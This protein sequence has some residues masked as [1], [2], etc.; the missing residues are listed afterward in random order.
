MDIPRIY[1]TGYDLKDG[2]SI[3]YDFG[4][5]NQTLKIGPGHANFTFVVYKTDEPEWGFRA[6]VKKYYEL[7]PRFFEKR[8]EREGTVMWINPGISK[9]PN[10]SDFGFAFDVAHEFAYSG[11]NSRQRYDIEN[12]IY[13]FQYTEPWGWWRSFGNNSTKPS[14]GERIAT[15]EDDALNGENKTWRGIV[16]LNVAAQAVM[17]SAPYD[18]NGKMYLDATDY[19]WNYWGN[20]MQNYPTNPDPDIPPPNRFEISYKKYQMAS[21]KEG[22]FIDN[23]RFEQNASWDSTVKHSGNHSA[24]IEILGN[25]SKISGRWISDEIPVKPNTTYTFSTW[26]KTENVGGIYV[27][28][29][30][31]VEIDANGTKN[32]STQRNLNFGSEVKDWTQK[33]LTFTTL[34]T[35]AKVIVYANI[36]K[37][38]GSFWFDDVELHETGSSINLVPN[39]GLELNSR[40]KTTSYDIYGISIDS[41]NTINGWSSLENHRRDHWK[42]VDLPLVFNYTTRKP[43]LLG[44]MSQYDYISRVEEA[45]HHENKLLYANIFPYS[46]VFYA[47]MIDILGS[48]IGDIEN[49][50]ISSMRRTLSYQK[51]NTNIMQ[52]KWGRSSE[53]ISHSEIENYISNE[54]FYG[55]FPSISIPIKEKIYG[56][57]RYWDNSTLYERD[58]DLF[59]KY[60]PMAKEISKAGWKPIPYATLDNSNIKIERYGDINKNSLYYTVYNDGSNAQNGKLTIYLIKQSINNDITTVKITELISNNTFTRRVLNG[61]VSFDISVN[62]KEV[63]IYKITI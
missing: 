55:I 38:Y 60:I 4:L 22:G 52:W 15:L 20:W 48:E 54:L 59:K 53:L 42:Y 3:Q 17:N 33:N 31:I 12:G 30:R 32:Y 8:N 47:H 7:Y 62:P 9:I 18:E 63:L 25:E 14:Y 11:D 37:G 36:W 19:F 21:S 13:T 35:T 51:T 23:W 56:K 1:R 29:V 34:N 27:P 10:A 26:G 40:E 45:I 58:R 28:A 50:E 5:S 43:I 2:Y 57:N 16:P 39:S 61:N 46:Y 6:V 44:V 49:D 24:K 41:L